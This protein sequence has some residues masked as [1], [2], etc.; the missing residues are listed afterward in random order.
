MKTRTESTILFT[1]CTAEEQVYNCY[2]LIHTVDA[3]HGYDVF[4]VFLT[5]SMNGELDEEFVYD[6]THEETIAK[7]FFTRICREHVTA[8]T[9][10]DIAKDFL[11]QF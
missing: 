8:C 11:A 5:T 10:Q 9:L 1:C 4:S 2:R 6:I 3:F 7:D